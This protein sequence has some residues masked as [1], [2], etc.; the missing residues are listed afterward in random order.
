MHVVRGSGAAIGAMSAGL[1]VTVVAL[2]DA[3]SKK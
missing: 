2:I 1:A 3:T